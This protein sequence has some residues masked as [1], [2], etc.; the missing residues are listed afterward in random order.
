[1]KIYSKKFLFSMSLLVIAWFGLL[2]ILERIWLNSYFGKYIYTL[3]IIIGALS[4]GFTIVIISWYFP[5]FRFPLNLQNKIL[6]D[7]SQSKRTDIEILK[8]HAQ[9]LIV[10]RWFVIA[11]IAS[12]AYIAIYYFNLLAKTLFIPL[13]LVTCLLVISNIFFQYLSRFDISIK[14]FII[15]QVVIDLIILSFLLH[16]SGGIENPFIFLYLFHVVITG[17]LLDKKSCYFIVILASLF[18]VFLTMGEMTGVLEHYSLSTFPHEI[19]ISHETEQI[20]HAAKMPLFVFSSI[21]GLWFT[22]FFTA[23]FVTEISG[24]YTQM[25]NMV[26]SEVNRRTMEHEKLIGV[27]KAAQVGLAVL[28]NN[29]KFDW[30]GPFIQSWESSLEQFL[31]S[32]ILKLLE[33]IDDDPNQSLS[34]EKQFTNPDGTNRI[35]QISIFSLSPDRGKF[36]SIAA[37]VQDVS[38]QKDVMAQL[39]QASKMAAIGELAGYIVHEVNNPV[40]IISSKSRLLLNDFTSTMHEKVESDLKNIV[41]LSDRIT[42]ITQGLLRF[43][44]PSLE[45]KSVIDVNEAIRRPLDLTNHS[46]KVSKIEVQTE[47]STLPLLIHGNLNEMEQVFFNL[48][49]NA[50]AAMSQGGN[51]NIISKLENTG[52]GAN[53]VITFCDTGHGIK[54]SI[55]DKIFEPFFTTKDIGEGTGL[56]LS[57]CKEI[58]GHSGGSIE[59]ESEIGKGSTFTIHLPYYLKGNKHK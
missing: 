31:K 2:Y 6:E 46:L 4:V 56:G 52:H 23:Y 11:V 17:I 33:E 53:V 55:K 48:I 32:A 58:I 28:D 26:F 19:D 54:P 14:K 42:H 50:K 45:S 20:I 9:W 7:T 41:H 39:I 27:I 21:F 44:R 38:K 8:H 35:F 13:I 51:L 12:V 15:I 16:F 30:V 1:M 34:I 24:Q 47:L 36:Q 40:S 59:V 25:R 10:M 29:N 37:L 43:S 49:T 57:V 18:Y 5:H 22:L 3:H